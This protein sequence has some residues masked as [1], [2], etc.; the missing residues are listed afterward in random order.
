ML[1]NNKENLITSK[2][3]AKDFRFCND[4]V[5]RS[6]NVHTNRQPFSGF[7]APEVRESSEVEGKK[8]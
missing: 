3:F 4:F 1:S 5:V 6:N 8:P 2:T 7:L